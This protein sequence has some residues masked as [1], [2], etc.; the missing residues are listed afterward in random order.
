MWARALEPDFPAQVEDDPCPVLEIQGGEGCGKTTL[1]AWLTE[2]LDAKS[3]PR[4]AVLIYYFHDS[5]ARV[6][7]DDRGTLAAFIAQILRKNR[8]LLDAD[9]VKLL[10]ASYNTI[11]SEDECY[12]ILK[13]LIQHFD[14]LIMLIDSRYSFRNTQF[15]KI[16]C[17]LMGKPRLEQLNSNRLDRENRSQPGILLKGIF[18]G[19]TNNW[20]GWYRSKGTR[21]VEMSHHNQADDEENFVTSKAEIVCSLHYHNQQPEWRLLREKIINQLRRE[22]RAPF[23]LLGSMIEYLKLQTNPQAVEE[24]LHN[25]SPNIR[26]IYEQAFLRI[27]N[28]QDSRTQLGFQILQWGAFALRSLHVSE[29]AEALIVRTGDRSLDPRRRHSRLEAHIREICGPFVTILDG[30][31]HPSHV[32]MKYFLKDVRVDGPSLEN[33][34]LNLTYIAN[35][36]ET[37]RGYNPTGFETVSRNRIAR[38]CVAYLSLDSFDRL[39]TTKRDE[40]ATRFPFLDYALHCWL[41]HILLLASYLKNPQKGY[42]LE[43]GFEREILEL[44]SRFVALPQSWTYLQSL[45]VFSSVREALE[46]LQSHMWPVRELEQLMRGPPQL[47]GASRKGQES[48]EANAL[49]SWMDRALAKLR[50]VQDMSVDEALPEL[51]DE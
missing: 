34:N 19:G 51:R 39:T 21:V 33:D 24:A 8:S 22:P 25:I 11:A 41:H 18:L 50:M 29:L 1:A 32:S 9:L 45:V 40:C 4:K 12:G 20:P 43:L 7:S 35:Y 15:Y 42:R 47:R 48:D 49:E 17:R 30:F 2:D 28:F 46:T 31:V 27:Q 14:L 16:L 13:R 26:A 36:N 44:V 37:R 6:S 10:K 23:L 3:K 38:A 5:D